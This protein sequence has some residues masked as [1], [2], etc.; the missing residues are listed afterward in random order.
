MRLEI[1][2]NGLNSVQR[3]QLRLIKQLIGHQVGPIAM[4]SYRPDF[5]GHPFNKCV[6]EALRGV[7]YWHKAEA[8]LLAAFVSK[9]N[10]CT[11]C[12]GAHTAIAVHGFATAT[13]EAA[14]ANWRDAPLRE[15]LRLT[16]GFLEKLTV[17]PT[18]VIAD[19]VAALYQAGVSEQGV[20]EAIAICF[21]FCTINRLAD[22][23]EFEMPSPASYRR[24]GFTLYNMG[25]GLAVLPG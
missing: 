8:E 11:Y 24:L 16:L 10:R 13:V 6:A 22:A 3:L 7:Q 19:D 23:F 18:A 4:Q 20:H 17:S 15:P 21:V 9:N 1:L 2:T 25:Y 14:L 5:F 12:M